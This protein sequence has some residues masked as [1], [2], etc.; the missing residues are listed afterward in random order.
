MKTIYSNI[1]NIKGNVKKAALFVFGAAVAVPISLYVSGLLTSEEA[2]TSYPGAEGSR[3]LYPPSELVGYVVL[4]IISLMIVFGFLYS[5]LGS[6][7]PDD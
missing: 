2:L 6:S 3:L 4:G 5:A 7:G 1:H